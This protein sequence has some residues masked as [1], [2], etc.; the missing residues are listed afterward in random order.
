MDFFYKKIIEKKLAI[1]YMIKKTLKYKYTCI[2]ISWKKTK[3][4][5]AKGM[6]KHAQ[7]YSVGDSDLHTLLLDQ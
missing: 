7:C 6:S 3:N 4:I 1:I 5:E 2:K